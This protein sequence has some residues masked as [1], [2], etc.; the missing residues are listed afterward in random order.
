LI[1]VLFYIGPRFENSFQD[2]LLMVFAC[3]RISAQG[4][5]K[6]VALIVRTPLE[7]TCNDSPFLSHKRWTDEMFRYRS[8]N[9][10]FVA[11]CTQTLESHVLSTFIETF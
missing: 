5:Y 9:C 1:T 10:D 8:K 7:M 11:R 3:D 2:Q 6:N 4:K